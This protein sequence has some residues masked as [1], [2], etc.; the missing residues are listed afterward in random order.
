MAVPWWRKSGLLGAA[1][2]ALTMF[3]STAPA[4]ADAPQPG[5]PVE[6]E[7]SSCTASFA[8]QGDDGGF[9]LMTSGHCDHH[10]GSVWTYAGG[11]PLGRITASEN[12]GANKDAAIIRLDPAAGAPIGDVGG[13]PVRGVFGAGEIQAGMPFCKLGAVSGETCGT[14]SSVEDDVV[15]A[16]VFSLKGDSGSP[17]FVT[18]PDGTVTA[19]GILMGSPQGDDNTTYFVLVSPLL[20]KWGLRLIA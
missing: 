18:N 12:D 19:V 11:A 7:S 15:T 8:A 9:Y 3:A 10:D 14:V 6:D 1:L 17:G 2:I 4:R 13:R 5:M 16:S 20:G